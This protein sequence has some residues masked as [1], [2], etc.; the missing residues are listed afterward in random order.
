[1]PP[2]QGAESWKQLEARLED[3]GRHLEEKDLL[4]IDI[5][6]RWPATEK[7]GLR[8]M[9]NGL[10]AR[11]WYS[12][13]IDWS[14]TAFTPPLAP[15]GVSPLLDEFLD[16]CEKNMEA[17]EEEG[18]KEAWRLARYLGHRLLSGQGLPEELV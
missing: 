1:M 14:E 4:R 16:D 3:I 9:I 15:R 5:R 12:R 10:L 11:S 17:A 18:I 7:E 2:W 13:E 6:G 8:E